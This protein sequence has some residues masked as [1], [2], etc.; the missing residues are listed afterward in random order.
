MKSCRAE[1][2]RGHLSIFNS[3]LSKVDSLDNRLP[4]IKALIEQDKEATDRLIAMLIFALHPPQMSAS[5]KSSMLFQQPSYLMAGMVEKILTALGRYQAVNV[6]VAGG[7][8][9]K[10]REFQFDESLIKQLLSTPKVF[11]GPEV[12]FPSLKNT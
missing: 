3:L 10:L 7:I 4:S 2:V 12:A 9:N 6:A 8:V 11:K 5:Y 1:D